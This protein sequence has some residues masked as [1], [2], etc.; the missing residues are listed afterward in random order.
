MADTGRKAT[1]HLTVVT[2]D[3]LCLL[4]REDRFKDR[5]FGALAV[6]H[7]ELI[8]Y[9]GVSW[10]PT[11]INLLLA[12]TKPCVDQQSRLWIE[13]WLPYLLLSSGT[14]L[15]TFPSTRVVP[16]AT[17]DTGRKDADHLTVVT[18]D[19]LCL[20][21]REDR[22]KDREFGAL[23]VSELI[24]YCGVSWFPTAINLLLAATKPCVDQQS[25]LWIEVKKLM[26]LET[27]TL[28][29]TGLV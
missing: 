14:A 19:V 21:H 2:P 20:L 6:G 1:N 28:D 18:P 23:A 22:F 12:A 13:V 10:F 7:S 15:H 3:V 27:Q 11:A 29:Q 17:A 4:H 26:T 24:G 16:I 8:G 9:C 25:R 5:E